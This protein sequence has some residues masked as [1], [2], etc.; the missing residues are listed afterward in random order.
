MS[1]IDND[2]VVDL[3]VDLSG[4][5]FP[6]LSPQSAQTRTTTPVLSQHTQ[7]ASAF[8]SQ[9]T[10]NA[11][12]FTSQQDMTLYPWQC[13]GWQTWHPPSWP[14]VLVIVF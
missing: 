14:Q 9:Q 12:A 11:S 7:N 8:T 5:G 1:Y 3:S 6:E 10:Q 2:E 13:P 4:T